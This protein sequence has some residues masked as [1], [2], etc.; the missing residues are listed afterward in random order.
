MS[1]FCDVNTVITCLPVYDRIVP[2]VV[3]AIIG[4]YD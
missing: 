2:E 3:T 4:S 1:A